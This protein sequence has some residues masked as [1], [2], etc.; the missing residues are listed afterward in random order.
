MKMGDH[1][2]YPHNL[3]AE[4]GIE[5]GLL[6]LLAL[7]GFL[8]ATAARGMRQWRD[9]RTSAALLV[10]L[11]AAQSPTNS[12]HINGINFHSRNDNPYHWNINF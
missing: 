5:N 2:F 10:F 6:G 9:A 4:V 11:F 3:F 1:R 7:A 12:F 8:I